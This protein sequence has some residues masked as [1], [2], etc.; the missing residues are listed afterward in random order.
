MSGVP[1][2]VAARASAGRQP[3]HRLNGYNRGVRFLASTGSSRCPEADQK[4][5][6]VRAFLTQRAAFGL[7]TSWASP[8]LFLCSHCTLPGVTPPHLMTS[9]RQG[10]CNSSACCFYEIRIGG[11]MCRCPDSHPATRQT[12]GLLCRPSTLLL[13]FASSRCWYRSRQICWSIS[14]VALNG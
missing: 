8:S 4:P 11:R 7:A 9:S 12:P 1:S 13:S 14:P 5:L 2:A 3:K 10:S 6:R